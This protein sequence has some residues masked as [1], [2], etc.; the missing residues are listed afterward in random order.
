MILRVVLLILLFQSQSFLSYSQDKILPLTNIQV[1]FSDTGIRNLEFIP[2]D[3][4]SL[5]I[6]GKEECLELIDIEFSD[7]RLDMGFKRNDESAVVLFAM[8][9][10]EL[11]FRL[12]YKSLNEVILH[13]GSNYSGIL[14]PDSNKL[15]LEMNYPS[16]TTLE[17]IDTDSLFISMDG[18]AQANLL[19][20]INYLK[21]NFRDAVKLDAK[22]LILESADITA[23][24]AVTIYVTVQNKL[25]VKS[26]GASRVFYSGNPN[27]LI[28]EIDYPENL[29]Q[30]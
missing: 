1:I 12:F 25:E 24:R 26:T 20:S 6:F 2:S 18:N 30:N 15:H 7:K 4:E 28:K 9:K 21:G 16:N 11:S 8:S 22:K 29:I 13:G 10:C 14:K 19:G 23:Q 5:E 27:H 3:R 17:I